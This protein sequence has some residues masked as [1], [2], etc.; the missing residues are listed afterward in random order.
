MRTNSA[1]AGSV[2]AIGIFPHVRSS[3]KQKNLGSLALRRQRRRREQITDVCFLDVIA[4]R[5]GISRLD[6]AWLR[7]ARRKRLERPVDQ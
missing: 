5:L 6:H 2:T 7:E 3:V 4:V 1:A